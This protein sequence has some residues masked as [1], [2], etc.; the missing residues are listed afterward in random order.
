MNPTENLVTYICRVPRE[1]Q[2][3]DLVYSSVVFELIS[4]AAAT[5]NLNF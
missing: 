2:S 5:Q 3:Y 4:N 1:L